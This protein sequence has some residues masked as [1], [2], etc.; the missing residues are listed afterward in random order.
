MEKTA[1]KSCV[2]LLALMFAASLGG[3]PA[4]ARD[5]YASF[6]RNLTTTERHGVRFRPDLE[7]YLLGA[8][9]AYRRGKGTG[10]LAADRQNL[11][12]ARAHAM[13]MALHD[14]V[15]HV[16]STGAGFESRV[17]AFRPGVMFLPSMGE[18]AARVSSGEP[19]TSAKASKLMT[20]WIKSAP[21]RKALS[22]RSYNSVATGVVQKGNRLYAVQIFS[23]P[24]VK[25][26]VRFGAP[27]KADFY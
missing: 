20:Q 23:G 12:A 6:A 27:A 9:N 19:A 14:F 17:R 21:H 15:G 1:M 2:W 8:A 26:N 22:S 16:S 4:Q 7:S 3:V 25:S 24:D 18:N 11:T 5:T 13:D 10:A